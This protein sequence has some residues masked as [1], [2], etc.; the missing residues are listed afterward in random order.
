M[1]SRKVFLFSNKGSPSTHQHTDSHPCTRS[2]WSRS[3]SGWSRSPYQ[4]LLAFIFCSYWVI[5]ME[6]MWKRYF[7]IGGGIL[8]LGAPI[9]SKFDGLKTRNF[10]FN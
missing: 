8:L 4:E 5:F 10:D 2:G 1:L 6:N 7:Q 3:L 9:K